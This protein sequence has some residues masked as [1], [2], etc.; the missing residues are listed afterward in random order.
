V[1]VPTRTGS[2]PVTV[3]ERRLDNGVRMAFIDAGDMF[4]R[5]GLYGTDHSDYPDNAARFAFFTRAALEYVRARGHRPSVFHSHDWQAATLA[6]WQK[7]LY[8]DD[9]VVGGVRTVFT[10]HNLGFQGI[11]PMSAAAAAGFP[12]A[13]FDIEAMEYW[14]QVSYLKGGITFSDRVSTVSPT[15]AREVLTPELGFGMDGVLRRRGRDFVGILNGLDTTR[16]DPATDRFLPVAYDT[17]S[18][19]AGKAAARR[20]LLRALGLPSTAG[21][22]PIVGLLSRMTDQKGF[23]LIERAAGDLMR[24]DATWVLLG[25]GDEPFERQWMQRAATFPDRVAAVIGFEERLAHLITAGSDLFLMP[26]RFEPCGLNQLHSLRYGTVPVVRAT[27]GLADTVEDTAD[28][29]GTGVVFGP[30]TPEALVGAVARG[31]ALAAGGNGWRALRQRGM[32]Q[33]HSWDVSAREYVKV[34]GTPPD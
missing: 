17:A 27:G 13:V 1:V 5:E 6:V 15:Y 3:V 22:R 16:W 10:I 31:L 21:E 2:T 28:G 33:D 34:Y 26:S 23:D 24:L 9:P 4:D 11:F 29:A 7:L 18:I 25:S 32:Q 19:D 12:G 8:A 20:E 14:G 30:Y